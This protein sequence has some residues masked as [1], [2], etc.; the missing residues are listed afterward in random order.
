[1]SY[2]IQYPNLQVDFDSHVYRWK[3]R[4]VPS[5]TDVMDRVGVRDDTDSHWS[6]VGCSDFAKDEEAANFGSALHKVIAGL[7]LGKKVE[8]PEVMSNWIAQFIMMKTKMKFEP[9]VDDTSRYIVEY[10]LYSEQYEFAGCVDFV[11]TD[12]NYDVC[13]VDWKS[14]AT[15]QKSY[16]WQTAAYKHLVKEVF[17]I[18]VKKRYIGLF[19]GGD[20]RGPIEC[21]NPSDFPMFLSFRNTLKAAA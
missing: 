19:D 17:N 18:N 16:G 20:Y 2:W 11:G 5:V 12:L 3:G 9:L 13:D 21:K 15:N 8:Y 1:M 4:V 10:P 14:S 7:F 6:P